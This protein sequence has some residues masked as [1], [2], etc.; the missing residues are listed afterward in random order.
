MTVRR[1]EFSRKTLETDVNV[2]ITLEGTGCASVQ[3]GIGFLDHLLSTLVRHARFDI[4]LTCKGDLVVDDHHSA[5]DCALALGTG[6]DR[7]LNGRKGIRRFGDAYAPLDE[8]LARAV[9]D[10]SGRPFAVVDLGLSRERL[11]EL[12][13]ENVTH[14]LNSFAVGASC[15][16]HVDVLRGENDHHRAEAAFKAVALA[17]RKA[18]ALDGTEDVPSTKGVL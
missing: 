14:F 3:T 6:L 12:S 7:A 16:L 9:V 2:G 4:E 17:L 5:E 11:G 1:A 13:C 15:A 18:V 8:A 10:L